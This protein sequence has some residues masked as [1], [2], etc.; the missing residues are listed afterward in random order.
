[1]PLT[2]L[3]T[4]PRRELTADFHCVAGWSATNLRWEGVPFESLYRRVIEPALPQGISVT[5]LVLRG[6]DG[7]RSV[8]TIQDALADDVLIADRLD[9]RPL[10]GDHGAPARFLSPQQYGYVN[11]KHL[12]RIDVHTA[13]P[14]GVHRSPTLRM[15]GQHPRARVWKEERH[16]Y[17]P[18][19]L[20]RRAYRASIAFILPR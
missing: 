18:P 7:W 14:K 20:L 8:V 4:L 16:R 17:L 3:E 11:T 10:D 12:C 9:G 2:V 19:W 15:L 5:H 1:M 6:L 13:E